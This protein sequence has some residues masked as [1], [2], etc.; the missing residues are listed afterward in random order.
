MWDKLR[1]S[2]THIPFSI[3]CLLIFFVTN[4][5]SPFPAGLTPSIYYFGVYL[6]ICHDFIVSYYPNEQIPICYF[7]YIIKNSALQHPFR[8][9]ASAESPSAQEGNGQYFSPK[10]LTNPQRVRIMTASEQSK[11]VTKRSNRCGRPTE[12][13]EWWKRGGERL[14]NGLRRADRTA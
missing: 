6:L 10:G 14:A 3:S 1:W 7:D 12:S 11:P 13:P 2:Q 9:I 4:G 8:E 5:F